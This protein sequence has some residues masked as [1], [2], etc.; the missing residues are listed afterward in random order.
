MVD[1][2]LDVDDYPARIGLIPAAIELL[3]REPKLDDKIAGEVLWLYVAA[4]LMPEPDQGGFVIP[5]DDPGIRAANERAPVYS[6][7]SKLWKTLLHGILYAILLSSI[8][9]LILRN[10]LRSRGVTAF[11]SYLCCFFIIQFLVQIAT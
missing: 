11:D 2:T 6:V 5:H 3:S 7:A 10:L 9:S 1:L 4:L 8:V